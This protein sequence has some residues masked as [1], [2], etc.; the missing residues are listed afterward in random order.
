M[1]TSVGKVISFCKEIDFHGSLPPD[2]L[3]NENNLKINLI[4]FLPFFTNIDV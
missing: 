3:L 1:S 4:I 2:E